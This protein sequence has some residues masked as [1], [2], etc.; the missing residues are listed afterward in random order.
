MITGYNT[1][2]SHA[3]VVFH[4]QTEDKGLQTAW[5]ESLIYVGGQILARQRSSYKSQLDEGGGSRVIADLMDRQ[6]RKM[7]RDIKLGK[8]DAKLEAL[9]GVKA[10]MAVAA[11]PT[12][13]LE[14]GGAAAVE[15]AAGLSLDDVILDYLTT[16]AES[17][18]LVLVMAAGNDLQLGTT[19]EMSVQA[20]S[21]VSGAPVESA[22]VSVKMISTIGEPA[23]LGQGETDAMGV[24]AL[25]IDIPALQRGTAA[26]IVS[27]ESALG[28]AE[29]KQLL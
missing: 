19:A 17:E 14:T 6:H 18:H 4:V 24:L 29:V 13:H 22:K 10:P 26:L 9:T 28:S 8:F 1:D 15:G 21:S 16:E 11:P 23:V 7:L 12:G 20:K 3:T 5:I 2:V 25:S 27:A